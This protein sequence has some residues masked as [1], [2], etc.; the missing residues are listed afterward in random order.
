M[1]YLHFIFESVNFPQMF[2]YFGRGDDISSLEVLL[3]APADRE[4]LKIG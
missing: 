4:L 3:V 1:R 2:K